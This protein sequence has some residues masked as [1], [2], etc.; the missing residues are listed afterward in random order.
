[1][2]PDWAKGADIGIPIIG[3]LW[4]ALGFKWLA[5]T[6]INVFF[7]RQQ[8]RETKRRFVGTGLGRSMFA[9]RGRA[10]QK[11]RQQRPAKRAA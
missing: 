9:P 4:R 10:M 7:K 6:M 11:G 3:T 5:E 1:M 2:L 8:Y